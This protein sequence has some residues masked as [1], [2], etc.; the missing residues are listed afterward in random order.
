[1]ISLPLYFASLCK[2]ARVLNI[3]FFR[4]RFGIFLAPVPLATQ[5]PPAGLA[6]SAV[7]GRGNVLK[8]K[9]LEHYKCI[10]SLHQYDIWAGS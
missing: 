6:P 4:A 2:R 5:E 3:S 10:L 9:N 7:L 8:E 1:M